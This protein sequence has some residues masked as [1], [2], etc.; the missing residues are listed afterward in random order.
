V[1]SFYILLMKGDLIRALPYIP[2]LVPSNSRLLV[3]DDVLEFAF[4][5]RRKQRKFSARIVA[6]PA[7]TISI[8]PEMDIKHEKVAKTSSQLISRKGTVYNTTICI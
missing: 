2:D 5:Y 1:V 4:G 7:C 8:F 3:I 6:G